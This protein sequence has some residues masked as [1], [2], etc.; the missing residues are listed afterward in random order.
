MCRFNVCTC[1][2]NIDMPLLTIKPDAQT[3]RTEPHETF[4][5]SFGKVRLPAVHSDDDLL[6][7]IAGKNEKFLAELFDRHAGIVGGVAMRVLRDREAA[8]SVA[9]AVF[10]QVW[11][12]AEGLLAAGIPVAGWLV[13]NARRRAIAA[14]HRRTPAA[15][16]FPVI[17]Y[18]L[19]GVPAASTLPDCTRQVLK[20]IPAEL[21][22][23]LEMAFF[24]GLPPN[25]IAEFTRKSTAEVREGIRSALLML[26]KGLE[27]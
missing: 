8:E 1:V 19:I 13:L 14:L 21:R 3:S 25:E 9:E 11:R 22:A 27:A 17:R 10:L 16:A 4:S 23:P 6:R 7:G 24:D 5:E 20:T 12:D 18:E 15:L 26:R 2:V